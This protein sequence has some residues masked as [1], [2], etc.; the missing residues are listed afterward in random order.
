LSA[1]ANYAFRGLDI[2]VPEPSASALAVVGFLLVCV[3][4][5]FRKS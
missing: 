4:R 3:R 1:G 5:F 2:V